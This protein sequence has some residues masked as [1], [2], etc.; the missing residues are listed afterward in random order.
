MW[1]LDHKIRWMPNNW[2]LQ[3]VALEKTLES[4]LDS[5]EIKP[6]KPKGNQPWIFIG[7]T[8]AEAILQYFGHVMQIAISLEKTLMLGRIESKRKRG[9][10]RMV[11]WHQWLNGH[12]FEQ[13]PGVGDGQGHLAC[14]SPCGHKKLVT[15]KEFGHKKLSAWT[16]FCWFFRWILFFLASILLISFSEVL[17]M[18]LCL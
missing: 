16:N 9:W 8:D 13:T 14:C 12:E 4:P 17:L 10:E 18:V 11:G 3:I 1:E 7:R 15:Q 6:V 2:C 5:K